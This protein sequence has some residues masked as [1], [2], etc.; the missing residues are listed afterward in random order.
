MFTE[1]P[2]E[3]GKSRLIS[4]SGQ[5]A[6]FFPTLLFDLWEDTLQNWS[7]CSL[8]SSGLARKRGQ[9]RPGYLPVHVGWSLDS[10]VLPGK[11]LQSEK[12]SPQGPRFPGSGNSFLLCTA[13]QT[14]SQQYSSNRILPHLYAPPTPGVQEPDPAQNLFCL[15]KFYPKPYLFIML[16]SMSAFCT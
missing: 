5:A 3:V 16:M 10:S 14:R 1:P 2:L 8:C 11:Q 4:V 12:P 7:T 6:S 9:M 15:I 13:G